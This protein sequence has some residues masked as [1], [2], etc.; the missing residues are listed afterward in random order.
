MHLVIGGRG[1]VGTALCAELAI[2][3]IAFTATCKRLNHLNE[4]KLDLL[5]LVA[6]DLEQ[7]IRKSLP[8]AEVVYLVAAKTG[9]G[10]C[11]G[12]RS[13]WI[14]NV[15]API[16]IARHYRTWPLFTYRCHIVFISSDAV[17]YCGATAYARQK[18][19]VESYIQSIDGAI[20]RAGRVG[21]RV[22]ELARVI[23]DVGVQRRVGLTRWQ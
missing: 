13:S 3:D 18:A 5:D 8:P 17:E 12:D 14:V 16:M 20:V 11:E 6:N 15:D 23:A 7:K 10:A 4:I 21:A 1:L 9:F 2:R 22:G 19:Q